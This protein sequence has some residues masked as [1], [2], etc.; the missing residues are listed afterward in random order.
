MVFYI[1]IYFFFFYQKICISKS[2]KVIPARWSDWRGF[3]SDS[4]FEHIYLGNTKEVKE[5]LPNT[6]KNGNINQKDEN[7]CG[8]YSGWKWRF[9]ALGVSIAFGKKD[10]FE[11]LMKQSGIDFTSNKSGGF[12]CV[13]FTNGI[14]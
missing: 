4:I 2:S 1:F 6:V 12:V 13:L 8:I 7:W 9:T 14:Y 10:I 5:M 11:I 3:P